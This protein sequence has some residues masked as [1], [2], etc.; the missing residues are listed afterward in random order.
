M[1]IQEEYGSIWAAGEQINISDQFVVNDAVD[2]YDESSD[3]EVEVNEADRTIIQAEIRTAPTFL[4]GT[5]TR[6]GREVRFNNR[7]LY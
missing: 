5:R 2:E 4:L 1:V 7:L 3:E 6:F